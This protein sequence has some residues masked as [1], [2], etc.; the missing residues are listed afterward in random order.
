MKALF[1]A[2]P[3]LL[4]ACDQEAEIHVQ[5]RAEIAAMSRDL[6]VL[7]GLEDR[8]FA[9]IQIEE[10]TGQMTLA[11]PREPLEALRR[12]ASTVSMESCTSN[13]RNELLLMVDQILNAKNGAEWRF[14]ESYSRAAETCEDWLSAQKPAS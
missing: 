6:A 13:A 7:N 1:L 14:A 2:I 5:R 9:L 4:A 3:F 8:I 12:E 10:K 11:G